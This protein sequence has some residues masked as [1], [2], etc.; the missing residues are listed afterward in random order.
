MES[1]IWPTVGS[2]PLG[3][4]YF[5]S[6]GVGGADI[7][8]YGMQ[9]PNASFRQYLVDDLHVGAKVLASDC[10]EHGD[11]CHLIEVFSA[12]ILGHIAVV[13]DIYFHR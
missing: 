6:H 11:G 2:S 8:A 10:L 1:E 3:N 4:M 13:G 12:A 9:Q 7:V 5:S